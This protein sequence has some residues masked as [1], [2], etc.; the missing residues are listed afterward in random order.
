[1]HPNYPI[2][3]ITVLQSDGV[4]MISC[5]PI[6]CSLTI[7]I[8]YY[9][10][11]NFYSNPGSVTNPFKTY[12]FEPFVDVNEVYTSLYSDRILGLDPSNFSMN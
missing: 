11:I 2:F 6:W 9:R 8:L 3:N 7:P 5:R 10:L 1:M 12:P 4:E